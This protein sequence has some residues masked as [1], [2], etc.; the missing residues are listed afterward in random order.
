MVQIVGLQQV[1]LDVSPIHQTFNLIISGLPCGGE[2]TTTF[3][4]MWVTFPSW[5]YLFDLS[6]G[7]L[8]VSVLSCIHRFQSD[9]DPILFL[10]FYIGKWRI[11]SWIRKL[12]CWVCG[13]PLVLLPCLLTFLKMQVNGCICSYRRNVIEKLMFKC[14]NL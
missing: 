14:F 1:I 7:Q 12:W 13:E 5:Q 6:Y 10:N 2:W 11:L 9:V 4:W 8:G 3:F